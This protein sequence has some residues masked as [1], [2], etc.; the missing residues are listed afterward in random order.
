MYIDILDRM[1]Q[2]IDP[3]VKLLKAAAHPTRLAILRQLSAEGPTCA[4]D[5]SD[6]CDELSQPTVSH[7]LRVLREAGWIEGE[8]RGTWIWYSIRPTASARLA[9]IAAGIG[10]RVARPAEGLGPA[11]APRQRLQVIQS[12]WRQW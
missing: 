4:C 6:C 10:P 2:A 8:R 11:R 12:A 1:G 3:D 9:D 7:H 5:V